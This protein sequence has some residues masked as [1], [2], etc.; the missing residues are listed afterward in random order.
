ML[1][2]LAVRRATTIAGDRVASE[3]IIEEQSPAVP[4][5]ALPVKLQRQA[6]SIVASGSGLVEGPKRI[7]RP[8]P[9]QPPSIP[10]VP[11]AAIS[12][13]TNL[14]RPPSQQEE[15]IAALVDKP[16]SSNLSL[17]ELKTLAD[18]AHWENR[19]QALEY[20]HSKLRVRHRLFIL[21]LILSILISNFRR[22]YL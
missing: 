11:V 21:H 14:P 12:C 7:A 6:N 19:V 17:D 13:E 1:S 3:S 22:Y 10:P 2:N 15:K 4:E 16:Q 20:V 8:I 18:H 9:R 5:K